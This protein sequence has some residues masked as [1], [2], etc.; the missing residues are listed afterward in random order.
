MDDKQRLAE[1]IQKKERLVA[2]VAPS[3]LVMYEYPHVITKL[4]QLGFTYVVEVSAGAKKTNEEVIA[5]LKSN[6]RSRIITSP[7]PGFVRVIRAKFPQLIPYLALKADSPMIATSRIAK[8]AYPDC[9]QVFIGPCI[10]KKKESGE[11]YPELNIIVITYKEL[12][13]IFGRFNIQ[14][15]APPQ[16]TDRFDIEEKTTRTYPMD[17]GLTNTSGVRDILKDEEIRIVS[18]WN[19]IERI[20]SEFEKNPSIRFVDVLLCEGGCINGPGIESGLSLEERA[21]KVTKSIIE[22]C[23][24]REVKSFTPLNDKIMGL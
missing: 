24:E 4:R 14:D 11:D 13:D 20:L 7:C 8:E 23:S 19:H 21:K 17:G 2:M 22:N 15:T 18:G 10:L 9:Q 3:Y 6:P 16:T 5:L 1:L 12:E